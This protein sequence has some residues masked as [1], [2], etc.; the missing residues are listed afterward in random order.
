VRMLSFI[1]RGLNATT[2]GGAA[3][4]LACSIVMPCS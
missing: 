2:A 1:G 4:E 3:P